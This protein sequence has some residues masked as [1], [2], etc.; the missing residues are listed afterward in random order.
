MSFA[1]PRARDHRGNRLGGQQNESMQR[2]QECETLQEKEH[3]RWMAHRDAS[4]HATFPTTLALNG[5]E[6][7]IFKAPELAALGAKR[8]KERAM[9]L[10]DLVDSTGSRFF[11]TYPHLRLNVYSQPEFIVGWV[12]NVQVA[13]AAALGHEDLDHAAFEASPRQPP[14]QPD[15]TPV[16]QPASQPCW[17]QEGVHEQKTASP[18]TGPASFPWS[19]HGVAG[20]GVAQHDGF[21]LVPPHL[22]T[23]GHGRGSDAA[24]NRHRAMNSSLVLG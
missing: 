7:P 12:I 19:Q 10:R 5:V 1:P 15:V 4:L 13:L 11:E 8:L 17:A 2:Y 9:N 18:P 23:G 14:Q 6:I 24:F 21:S 20:V 22:Q 3:K 16:R